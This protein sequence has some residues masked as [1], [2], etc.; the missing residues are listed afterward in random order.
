MS[1]VIFN[2][3][4]GLSF[5]ITQLSSFDENEFISVTRKKIII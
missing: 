3:L 2:E 4:D 1:V 5:T